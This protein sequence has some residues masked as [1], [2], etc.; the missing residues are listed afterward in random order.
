MSTPIRF[1]FD[2]ISHN[3][4][5]AWTQIHKLAGKYGREVEPVPVLFAAFLEHFG[6][7]GPAEMP[8]KSRW[9]LRDVVRKAAQLNIPINPPA[10][11][12][13]NPLLPLRVSCL[14]LPA[15]DKKRLI[16]AIYRAT[17]ADS[18]KIYEP[19]VLGAVLTNAGFDA[20]DMLERARDDAVK[21]QLRQAAEEAIGQGVFGVPTMCIDDQL[22][23]GYDDLH[24]M[25]MYLQGRDPLDPSRIS[26][27]MQV[28]PAIH[29]KAIA[30][31]NSFGGETDKS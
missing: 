14:E 17:W 24:F 9:M 10:A 22:F 18:R 15:V 8:A 31:Q 11:H 7:K 27:W 1:Y 16:D 26:P 21:Q 13:F 3:A 19:E 2:Y 29:R 4:Y 25:E 6:Q 20:Q 30:A 23:W 12:P 5:L 28:K